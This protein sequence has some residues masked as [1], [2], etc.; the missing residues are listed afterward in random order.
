MGGFGSGNHWSR[1]C[2]QTVVEDCL[3][4]DASRWTREGILKAGVHW[5][6]F[7]RWVINSGREC[8]IGYRV[9][10]L[11]MGRPAVWLS[12]SRGQKSDGQQESADY[13][14]DLTVTRPRFGGLRW[15]FICPLVVGGRPCGRRVG[16][17]YLP[18]SCRYFGCRHCYE[19]TYTSCRESHKYDTL[20]RFMARDMGC[21]FATARW[22]MNQFGKRWKTAQE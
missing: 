14:V 22:T 15:W 13:P 7:W 20:Y 5:A 11:D 12:Y 21:D 10:T 8:S 9:Q 4:I 16:K 19:L 6:G 3:S 17:L 1:P 2:K 18:P